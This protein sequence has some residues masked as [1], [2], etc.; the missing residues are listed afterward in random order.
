[1]GCH[2][3][4]DYEARLSLPIVSFK[5]H[6]IS[7]ELIMLMYQILNGLNEVCVLVCTCFCVYVSACLQLSMACAYFC[8]SP[9]ARADNTHDDFYLIEQSR[10]MSYVMACYYQNI[11]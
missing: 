7:N 8:L 5:L 1:M 6:Q 3:K 4:M 11:T 10:V 2:F 9:Y